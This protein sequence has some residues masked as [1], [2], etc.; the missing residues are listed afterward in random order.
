MT[1][2]RF[3]LSINTK[4]FLRNC[5]LAQE[6]SYNFLAKQGKILRKPKV[7]LPREKHLIAHFADQNPFLTPHCGL[8]RLL[9]MLKIREKPQPIHFLWIV[10]IG[11]ILTIPA[12]LYSVTSGHDF[13]IHWKWAKQFSEQ[14][15]IGDLYPRWLQNMNAGLGSPA[16]FFYPPIAYYFTSLFHPLFTAYPDRWYEITSSASLACLASGIT[17]YIWLK[18][19]TNQRSAF[20]ASILYMVFPYHLSLCLYTRFAFAEFWGFVWMPLVLYFSRKIIDEGKSGILGFAVSYALLT[21]THLPTT[22]IFSIIPISY[23]FLMVQKTK[24]K[25]AL[26]CLVAAL[27]L[28]VG[29]SAI[30]LVPA[31]TTQK[32]VS[33]AAMKTGIFSYENNFLF[34]RIEVAGGKLFGVYL[35]IVSVLMI[36]I[37]CCF[38]LTSIRYCSNT[39]T[40]KENLYWLVIV[41]ASTFMISP[42]SLPIWRVL[43]PIQAI[44]FPWRFSSLVTVAT[45]AVVALGLFSIEKPIKLLRK[46]ESIVGIIFLII[47]LLLGTLIMAQNIKRSSRTAKDFNKSNPSININMEVKEYRPQWVSPDIYDVTPLDK[48]GK[49]LDKAQIAV[50]Q[51]SVSVQRWN[52]RNIILQTNATT[53]IGV[54]IKQFYYPGWTARLDGQSSVLPTQPSKLEG[55]LEVGIPRGKHEVMVTMDAGL[56]ERIGQAIGAVS[57]LTA[58]FLGFWLQSI[59]HKT[60]RNKLKVTHE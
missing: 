12:S 50:G 37:S 1:A 42:L 55:L 11:L 25:E 57:A 9:G 34:N 39:T 44:Q 10:S 40:R 56:E 13:L 21:M 26:I 41:L 59:R 48:L 7:F 33:M 58:L 3:G 43:T 6:L 19:I 27:I 60:D 35:N 28:G 2:C 38:A 31:M 45:T 22:L 17:A 49:S 46:R 24:R 51:G 52:P 18:S 15:W 16:F 29:L 4:T 20:I 47:L 53:D 36:L 30:Y 32:Y 23:I 5:R 54:K 14:I 8:L